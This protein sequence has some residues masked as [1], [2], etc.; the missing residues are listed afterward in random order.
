[1]IIKTLTLAIVLVLT[2]QAFASEK[3]CSEIDL[4]KEVV[5]TVCI[6]STNNRFQ[7]VLVDKEFGIQDLGYQGSV[8]FDGKVE[9]LNYREAFN[10]CQNV[11]KNRRLPLPAEFDEANRR[12]LT[13]AVKDM[14]YGKYGKDLF[15]TSASGNLGIDKQY[16]VDVLKA[17]G[18]KITPEVQEA[19]SDLE[20]NLECGMTFVGATELAPFDCSRNRGWSNVFTRCTYDGNAQE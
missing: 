17:R 19:L 11:K 6:T 10:Y 4:R 15:W 8:W 13:E 3:K 12:G 16:L 18:T 20:L 9:G 2:Q 1:M 5:G 7:R 14:N